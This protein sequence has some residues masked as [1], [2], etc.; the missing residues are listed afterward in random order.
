LN[1]SF[2]N[3]QPRSITSAL[4]AITSTRL[5]THQPSQSL[6]VSH[7][8]SS[9]FSQPSSGLLPWINSRHGIQWLG[10]NPSAFILQSSYQLS[11]VGSGANSELSSSDSPS[12]IR[13]LSRQATT[14][15]VSQ[16][17]GCPEPSL[18]IGLDLSSRRSALQ[19]RSAFGVHNGYS[20]A[21]L[22]TTCP[23]ITLLCCC[24]L[25]LCLRPHPTVQSLGHFCVIF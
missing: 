2:N 22:H 9:T 11:S 6:V 8:L 17:V 19:G 15:L 5:N 7:Q 3:R 20:V 18:T 16:I 14:Q 25:Y 23:Y 12:A 24:S 13:C 21:D 10:G 1:N 4:S